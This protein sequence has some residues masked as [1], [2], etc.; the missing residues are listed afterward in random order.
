MVDE[1]ISEKI[2]LLSKIL[3]EINCPKCQSAEIGCFL[4]PGIFNCNDCQHEW[5]ENGF[6]FEATKH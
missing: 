1:R 3:S 5:K 4:P 2:K 6:D